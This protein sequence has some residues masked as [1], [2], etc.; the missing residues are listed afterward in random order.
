M[1]VNMPLNINED[2]L[3]AGNLVERPPTEPTHMSYVIQ[4]L[5]I[6]IVARD[7]SNVVPIDPGNATFDLILSLDA[8]ME[9]FNQNLPAFFDVHKSHTEEIRMLDRKYPYLPI[10]R[11]VITMILSLGRCKLHLHYLV[12]S[13]DMALHK[14]SRDICLRSA[15]MALLA[16]KELSSLD[17]SHASDYMKVQGTVH[18]LFL[19]AIILATDLCCNRPTGPERDRSSDELMTACEVL[20]SVKN[21][22]QVAAKFLDCLTRLLVKYG[23]WS[24][25]STEEETSAGVV[26][27]AT[28]SLEQR[29]PVTGLAPAPVATNTVQED[30]MSQQWMFDQQEFW[31][32]PQA[33]PMQ[34]NDLWE[35]YVG[36]Q[37]SMEL[38]DLF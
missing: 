25:N 12:G 23:V 10:Q 31:D 8:Q 19:V 28:A 2:D 22:S 18:H 6:A 30:P 27:A 29:L 5:K 36:Q 1:T 37:S 15:R 14:F 16:H 4:R 17:L 7:F 32:R 38:I 9:E 20:A 26:Q 21:Q 33:G 11:L 24:P 34:F 35:M 13:P 3:A